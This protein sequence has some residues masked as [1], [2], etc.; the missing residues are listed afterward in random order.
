[1]RISTRALGLD[2]PPQLPVEAPRH[3]CHYTTASKGAFGIGASGRTKIDKGNCDKRETALT[4]L[5]LGRP[6]IGVRYLCAQL[7]I[8]DCDVARVPAPPVA[9][10][11]PAECDELERRREVSATVS[12]CRRAAVTAD[13]GPK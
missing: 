9:A 8:D 13:L 4:F 10:A 1:M 12:A 3:P 7:E 5:E 2:L 11:P 6:D